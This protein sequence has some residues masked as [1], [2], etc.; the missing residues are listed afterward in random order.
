MKYASNISGGNYQYEFAYGFC[1][2]SEMVLF[3][4]FFSIYLRASGANRNLFRKPLLFREFV[5]WGGQVGNRLVGAG[6]VC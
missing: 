1:L 4:R 2:A 5:Q 3:P 6:K